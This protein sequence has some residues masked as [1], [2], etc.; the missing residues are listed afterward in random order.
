[1]YWEPS[2]TCTNR[3]CR[4]VVSKY[5]WSI[6]IL[7]STFRYACPCTPLPGLPQGGKCTNAPTGSYIHMY[8]YKPMTHHWKKH[9]CLCMHLGVE[10]LT[11]ERNPSALVNSLQTLQH[12]YLLAPGFSNHLVQQKEQHNSILHTCMHIHWYRPNHEHNTWAVQEVNKVYLWGIV[13]MQSPTN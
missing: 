10:S 4:S 6:C 11:S 12:T 2:T 13:V 1:M 5:T 8:H 7:H 9:A 3:P